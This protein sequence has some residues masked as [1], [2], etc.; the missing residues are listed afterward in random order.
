M[1]IR[2]IIDALERF[3]PLP[4]QD[5]YDNSGLQVGTTETEVSGALL[6][7]DVT[8]Q[9]VDEAIRNGCNLIVSHHP[10]LFRPLKRLTDDSIG[11][12]VMDAVR[13]GITIYA[14]HTNL[15]NVSNGVNLR[16]ARVLGLTDVRPLDEHPD[17]NGAGIIGTFPEPL[18]GQ[19]LLAIVKERFGV[20]CI[21]HN[22]E[23]GRPI[24]RMA[25]C[26]GAGAF[27]TDK[28]VARGADAFMT[29]EIGYHRFFGYDGTIK[30]IEAGHFESEQFT[31]DLLADILQESFPGLKV[32]KTALRTNPV[33][34]Y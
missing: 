33:N 29:G 16:I 31:V 15:D 12:I 7:L 30:L 32:L 11:S 8:R 25:V 5:D 1:N 3:A 2:E 19:E 4:L 23:L 10:L 13:A 27:L 34:Y 24:R 14:C 17:G 28:A 21:R 22:G 9:V 26:G 6:C 18:S 20:T